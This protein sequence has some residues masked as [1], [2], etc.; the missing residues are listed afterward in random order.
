MKKG[1]K[2]DLVAYTALTDG[3]CRAGKVLEVSNIFLEMLEK[4]RP[5]IFDIHIVINGFIEQGKIKEAWK[6]LE[7]IL[8]AG[9]NE[10]YKNVMDSMRKERQLRKEAVRLSQTSQPI[11]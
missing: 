3:L 11:T 5:C 10:T 2:T 4:G 1:P 6:L 8:K 9:H 7:L